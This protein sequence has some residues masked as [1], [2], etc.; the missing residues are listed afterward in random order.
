[1]CLSADC[2][3]PGVH[4]NGCASSRAGCTRTQHR[5][6]QQCH[7]HR[8][9]HFSSV[10]PYQCHNWAWEGA[11]AQ[12]PSTAET[13]VQDPTGLPLTS[14]SCIATI[15]LGDCGFRYVFWP[16]SLGSECMRVWVSNCSVI[17]PLRFKP[18]CGL[19]LHATADAQS[20]AQSISVTRCR[21]QA[22]CSQVF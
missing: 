19:S 14:M 2:V 22:R 13:C 15:T 16:G 10:L 5:S 18:K 12:V 1:M 7:R 3:L 21:M 6:F 9:W 20:W 4:K 17:V 8:V 11:S